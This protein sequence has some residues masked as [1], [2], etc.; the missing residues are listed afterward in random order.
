MG[1]LNGLIFEN[2]IHCVA[3]HNR[4]RWKLGGKHVGQ[5]WSGQDPSD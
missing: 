1:R 3:I 2:G 5:E 4:W